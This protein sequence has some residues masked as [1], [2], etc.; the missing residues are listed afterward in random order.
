[1]YIEIDGA[2]GSYKS[3]ICKKLSEKL[4]NAGFSTIETAQPAGTAAANNIREMLKNP[5]DGALSNDTMLHLCLA[6]RSDLMSKVIK[7]SLDKFDVV[8]SDRGNLCTVGLQG[9]AGGYPVEEIEKSL[10]QLTDIILPDI[11]FL[12]SI[13]YETSIERQLNRGTTD[14]IEELGEEYHRNAIDGMLYY[15]QKHPVNAPIAKRIQIIDSVD[16]E[17]TSDEIADMIFDTI[18]KQLAKKK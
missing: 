18:S 9:F 5:P 3:S 13:S 12:V 8:L 11:I 16:K 4:A 14:F 15:A 2:E 1:M 7:P 6:A 10:L 17:L